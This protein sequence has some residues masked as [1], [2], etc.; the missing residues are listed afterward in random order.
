MPKKQKN[1]YRSVFLYGQ[2]TNKKMRAL[3][4]TENTYRDLINY[5][6]EKMAFDHQFYLSILTNSKKAPV[7]RRLE[8]NER[9][10][11]TL[12]SAYGQNAIDVAVTQLHNHFDRIKNK[13][14]GFAYHKYPALL[15]FISSI[16]AF[17]SVLTYQ[18]EV[19]AIEER[20]LEEKNKEKK[21]FYEETLTTLFSY[22]KEEREECKEWVRTLFYEKLHHWKLP[23]QKKATIQLDTRLCK[24][25]KAEGIAADYVISVKLVGEKR[26]VEIPLRTSENSKRRMKQYKTQSPTIALRNG[27]VKVSVPFEKKVK[28]KK[29]SSTV[30]ADLGITD[31]IYTS[32]G[33]SYGSFTGMSDL[34]ERVV[35]PKLKQRSR[36]RSLAKKYRKKL[37]HITD[38]SLRERYLTKIH[39]IS[40]QLNQTKN[41]DK[42]RRKYAHAVDVRLHQSVK[43][44]INEVKE[45]PAMVVLED[46]EIDEFNRGKK[47]NKR[48]SM[49]VRGELQKKV[50][51]K[52]DWIGIPYKLVD[53][54]Y[55]SKC[56]PKCSNIDSENRE[57]KRFACT[58]C[59]YTADADYVA[60]LNIKNRANDKELDD[61]VENYKWDTK[62]R[63]QE[64]KR[65]FEL[66]RKTVAA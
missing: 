21:D 12:G 8:E 9:K 53:P 54:A 39:N 47:N 22:E 2:P 3:I 57:G 14:Y 11:H 26:R 52:L 46:L 33:S 38:P 56:C 7:V 5:F 16:T 27:K 36:L 1:A 44:F 31:L 50:T 32:N 64:I 20:F 13:I 41:L 65:L 18:D 25:E 29:L 61:I 6:I 63:H 43:G 4:N 55:T 62:K 45:N 28:S 23:V 10:N 35:Q 40:N 42:L 60:S 19:K 15:P 30:G 17:H 37:K 48:D 24:I 66:R 59:K 34:Y 51:E 49:W 58:V